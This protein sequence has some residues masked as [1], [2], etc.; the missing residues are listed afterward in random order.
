LKLPKI[1]RRKK[2]LRL[3]KTGVAGLRETFFGASPVS[4]ALR[5]QA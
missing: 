3:P 5:G 2:A 1:F 4:A